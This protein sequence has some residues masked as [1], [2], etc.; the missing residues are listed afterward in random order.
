[1]PHWRFTHTPSGD[2][3]V[4]LGARPVT[5]EQVERAR[6]GLA[7]LSLDRIEANGLGHFA[8]HHPALGYLAGGI[9][10]ISAPSEI[11]PPT[12]TVGQP[13]GHYPACPPGVVPEPATAVLF[14]L[15]LLGMWWACRRWGGVSQ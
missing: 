14:G 11:G 1:M 6:P 13:I 7:A 9:G 4:I 15:G 8:A 5:W 3:A 10:P 12:N 2:R